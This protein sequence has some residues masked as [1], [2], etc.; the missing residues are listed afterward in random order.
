M[1]WYAGLR[2]NPKPSGKICNVPCPNI[3]PRDFTHC[4]RTARIN[5]CRDCFSGFS[6][7]SVAASATNSSTDIRCKS[8]TSCSCLEP[9]EF[10]LKSPVF[11]RLPCSALQRSSIFVCIGHRKGSSPARN[12]DWRLGSYCFGL[13]R[14][15]GASR[16]LGRFKSQL[17]HFSAAC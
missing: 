8:V 12:S 1:Y 9:S 11:K 16:S 5:S 17:S 10:E 7:P 13:K 3:R 4:F 6:M 14:D 2:K 15:E